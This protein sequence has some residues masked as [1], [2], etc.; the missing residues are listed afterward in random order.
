MKFFELFESAESDRKSARSKCKEPASPEQAEAGTYAKGHFSWNGLGITIE[1]PKDGIRR[2]V[3]KDGKEWSCK[4]V[5]DYGYVKK[6]ESEADGD[7]ID[8]FIGPNLDSE[9]VYVVDQD[10]NGNHRFDEHK[11]MIGFDSEESARKGYLG[12]Y[13]KGWKG[14]WEIVPLTLKQFKWWIFNGDTGTPLHKQKTV[15]LSEGRTMGV[16]INDSETD[17]TGMILRGEK[18]IETRNSDSLRAYVGKSVGIVRTGKGKA[19]LV[20][21]MTIGEPIHYTTNESFR[22]DYKRHRVGIGSMFDIGPNGKF[23]YPLLDVSPTRER[24]LTTRG[25]VSRNIEER[26][27]SALEGILELAEA[28]VEFDQDWEELGIKPISRQ[29]AEMAELAGFEVIEIKDHPDYGDHKT[30]FELFMDTGLIM[31]L[32]VDSRGYVKWWDFKIQFEMGNLKQPE[33]IIDN[34]FRIKDG[35]ISHTELRMESKEEHG[36]PKP[37]GMDGV[38]LGRDG[39]GFFVYTHRARSNSYKSPEKIPASVVKDIEST[40]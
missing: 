21:Y 31:Y 18:T 2:G 1:T 8:V 28:Y 37:D 32:E 35:G 40:G 39:D 12:N 10:G 38:S 11:C 33:K 4:M 24:I 7:H 30:S 16:N 6:T 34:F 26:C 17:W 19:T 9:I 20:G 22:S 3:S 13:E 29:V 27:V 23:G 14:D 36:L 15:K 5:S 25:I